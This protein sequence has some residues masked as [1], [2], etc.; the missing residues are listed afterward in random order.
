MSKPNA[1]HETDSNKKFQYLQLSVAQILLQFSVFFVRW[2][3]MK[4]YNKKII[5][6]LQF[7]FMFLL[8]SL[9]I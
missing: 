4:N 6:R 5:Q 9:F 7:S 8:S 2:Q 3:T 1:A